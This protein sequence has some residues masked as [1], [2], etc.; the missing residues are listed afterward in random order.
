M[1][2]LKLQRQKMAQRVLI[3]T[4]AALACIICLF[5][6]YYAILTSLR[7]GQNLFRVGWLPNEMNWG[8][9]VTALM[10]SGI[11]RSLLNSAIV[12]TLT[13]GLCLLVSITAAF[14]LARI[15]FRGRKYLLFTILCVSM[16]PQIAVLSGMFELV[17][18]MGLYDSLGALVLSYTTF[19]LPFTIWVLTT[20][21]K[22]IPT[23][24]EEAAIV[25]GA[26][27]WTIISRIFA[28]IMGPSLVTTGLLAFIGAW[29]E[30]K[31]AL[32]FVISSGKRTVPVA[33][34]ML[35]GSSQYELPWGT[36]MASS[37]IVTLPIVALVLIFQRRIVSGLTHGAVKG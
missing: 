23:E 11:A 3:F 18:F 26:S 2:S 8:N 24:L 34:G 22:A 32:T 13:V 20:F 4:S 36:I 30:F 10:D 16:F 1:M 31:F 37:V 12:A 9:Y 33:I 27:T 21:M 14:A 5:P 19:S 35:Q 25:D 28:P 6:F 7:S 15:G 17:R 29:N